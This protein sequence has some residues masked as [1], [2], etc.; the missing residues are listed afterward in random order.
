MRLEK[1]AGRSEE[2]VGCGVD[3][4]E[5]GEDLVGGLGGIELVGDAFELGLVFVEVGVG[6]LEQMVERDVDHLVVEELFAEGVGAEA[7]VAVGAGEEIGLHPGA[8]G[9]EG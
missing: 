9:L 8:V 5:F 4:G 3:G 1:V 6:D 2:L 7:V